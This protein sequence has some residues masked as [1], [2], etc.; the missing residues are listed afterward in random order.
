MNFPDPPQFY[1]RGNDEL[2]QPMR[3]WA[4]QLNEYVAAVADALAEQTI[5]M[6]GRIRRLELRP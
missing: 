5:D 3:R 2:T 4:E 6:Q 1:I